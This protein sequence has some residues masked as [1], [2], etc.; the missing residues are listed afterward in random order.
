MREITYQSRRII[1]DP[2]EKWIA[3]QWGRDWNKI[4]SLHFKREPIRLI[5]GEWSGYTSSQRRIV[6]RTLAPKG[7]KLGY[8][9]KISYSDKTEMET[10]IREYGL[11]EIMQLNL[12]PIEGYREGVSEML[13]GKTHIQ[14]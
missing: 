3:K 6:H 1:L 14:Y 4:K 7:S 9:G 5:E 13:K 10:V 8:L 12:I 2:N 11:N